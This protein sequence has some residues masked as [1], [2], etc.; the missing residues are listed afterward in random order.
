MTILG[1]G[2]RG[3]AAAAF[4]LAGAAG[5]APGAAQAEETVSSI[6]RGARLYDNW[7]AEIKMDRPDEAHPSY[8]S[9][10]NYERS[11]WR[12][13]EC[14]GWDYKGADGAY[15][16][17]RHKTGFPGIRGAEGKPVEEIIAILKDDTHQYS[18]DLLFDEDYRDLALFVS[19][20]QIDMDQYI[21]P[22]S[23][24]V[25][26]DAGRGEVYYN[27]LCAGCHDFDGKGV[28]TGPAL[29]SL[30]DNPWEI[31]HKALNG[32]P[33]EAMPALRSLDTQIA[34]DLVAYVQ[35]LPD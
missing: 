27:T 13:K 10:G 4:V 2:M 5:A 34:V 16:S 21:D 3:I 17:G 8:P 23:K 9:D 15:G 33:N 24:E 25:K 30:R 32:Q 22:A 18:E 26:G 12:C 7:Y 20:G 28:S 35:T 31:L 14:H 6:A 29:G 1:R 11:S 19:Q